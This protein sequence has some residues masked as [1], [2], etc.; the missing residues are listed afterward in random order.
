MN[1]P[2][3]MPLVGRALLSAIF[4]H[5][6]INHLTDFEGTQQAIASQGLPLPILLAMGNVV[7][8]LLGGL[9]LLLG[10]KTRIGT[11]I[12]IIFLLPTTLIFHNPVADP[13]EITDFLKN[14]G[15][16]GALLLVNYFGP[17]PISLDAN[18][19]KSR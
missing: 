13:A 2:K 4:L 7:F 18:T 19:S 16:V 10:Y 15:L 12:L 17:G 5:A 3:F 14:F 1:F 9:S 11:I 6:G 8:L